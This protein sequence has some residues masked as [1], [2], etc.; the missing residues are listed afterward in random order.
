MSYFLNESFL[1]RGE[2]F[3]VA[4]CNKTGA[5]AIYN[6]H[7]MVPITHRTHDKGHHQDNTRQEIPMRNCFVF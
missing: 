3:Y 2:E 1:V 7:S 6:G 4:V 5:V